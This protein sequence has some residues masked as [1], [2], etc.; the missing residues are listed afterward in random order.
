MKYN[1]VA[2]RVITT[3]KFSCYYKSFC[4][5]APFQVYATEKM[6]VYNRQEYNFFYAS[7]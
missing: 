1:G 2:K 3:K 6:N 4:K 5:H 7:L